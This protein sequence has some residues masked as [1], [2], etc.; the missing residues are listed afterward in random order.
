MIRVG[1]GRDIHR[2]VPGRRFLAGGVAIPA[3]SGEAGHSDADVLIHAI[4]DALLGAAGIGDCGEFFPS[5]DPDYLDADSKMLLG[6][7]WN[8]I[9]ESGW[10]LVNLDCVITCEEPKILPY[11][12]AI[13][14]S[15][16]TLLGVDTSAIFVKGKTNEGCDS[17][18]AGTAVEALALCLLE[19]HEH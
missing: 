5:N 14:E 13:R 15:L 4:I 11:R 18:G 10:N 7:A 19:N 8:R 9:Q 2:L 6:I 1:L 16:A 12:E 17:T 3:E